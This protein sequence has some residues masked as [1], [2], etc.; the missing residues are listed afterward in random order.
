[1][2]AVQLHYMSRL[3]NSWWT[4]PLGPKKD[5]KDPKNMSNSNVRIQASIENESSSTTWVDPKTIF[6]PH[7][8][9]KIN[10]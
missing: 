2:K 6:N 4:S 3:Q 10:H 1:M 8:E 7:I 5:K 9:P